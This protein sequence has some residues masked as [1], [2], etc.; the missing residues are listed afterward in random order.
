L[1]QAAASKIYSRGWDGLTFFAELHKTVRMFRGVGKRLIDIL[2]SAR[3][4]GSIN[5]FSNFWLETRYGWRILIFDIKDINHLL[6]EWDSKRKNRVKDRVGTSK[7]WQYTNTLEGAGT[8]GIYRDVVT[9]DH[10][11][12]VRGAIIADFL[13]PR[14]TLNPVTTSWELVP[15]SFVVDW[16]F[17]VGQALEAIS[18]ALQSE[19]TSGWGV[20]YTISRSLDYELEMVPSVT[21]DEH[22]YITEDIEIWKR[23]PMAVPFQPI[24]QVNLNAFKV[25]DLLA[26]V[27][28]LLRK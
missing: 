13:P 15:F 7:T 24:S 27:A 11:L 26:L 2:I 1:V 17:G 5:P 25:I 12:N 21:G 22:S 14:I 4:K 8:A 3:D 16:F 20:H 18:F 19:Y 10:S 28:Q 6:Q 9:E 23:V